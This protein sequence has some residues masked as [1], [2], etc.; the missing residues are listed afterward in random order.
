MHLDVD[1]N[2]CH[3][4]LSQVVDVT[5]LHFKVNLSEF[6]SFAI[7]PK[8]SNVIFGIHLYVAKRR[9]AAIDDEIVPDLQIN[10]LGQKLNDRFFY[11]FIFDRH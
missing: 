2:V 6:Q 9:Y 10:L 4:Y 5:A 3:W 8:Q 7:V 1:K 11:R